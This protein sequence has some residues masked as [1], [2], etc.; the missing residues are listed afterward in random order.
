MDLDLAETI[1]FGGI[2]CLAECETIF[3]YKI[4]RHGRFVDK[5]GNPVDAYGKPVSKRGRSKS[6]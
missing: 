4:Q 1:G 6:K 3:L 2:P 5:E